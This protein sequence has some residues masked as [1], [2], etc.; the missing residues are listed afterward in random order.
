MGTARCWFAGTGLYG[1]SYG[2]EVVPAT[3]S[4]NLRVCRLP[5]CGAPDEV[6]EDEEPDVP[7]ED[8]CFERREDDG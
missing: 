1:D 3:E 2:G 5:C 4:R 8:L 7:A 6:D